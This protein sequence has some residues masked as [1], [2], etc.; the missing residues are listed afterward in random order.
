MNLLYST[1]DANESTRV[2]GCKMTKEMWDKLR[3]IYEGSD[4]V[5]EQKKSLLVTKY[6]PFKM[7][8]QENID[9][10]VL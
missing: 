2:K 4:N 7:E 8:P 5:R 6:K 10:N 3:E 9:K 1:L